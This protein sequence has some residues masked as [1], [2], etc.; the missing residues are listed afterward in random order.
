[1]G[2]HAEFIEQK[3]QEQKRRIEVVAVGARIKR[4]SCNRRLKSAHDSSQEIARTVHTKS[5]RRIEAFSPNPKLKTPQACEHTKNTDL[6]LSA[7][8][9]RVVLAAAATGVGD[10]EEDAGRGWKDAAGCRGKGKRERHA[11]CLCCCAGGCLLV[12]FFS[13]TSAHPRC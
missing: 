11:G 7:S 3:G 6:L 2:S 8:S 5:K 1:M 9:P 4:R 12:L 13:L 10:G